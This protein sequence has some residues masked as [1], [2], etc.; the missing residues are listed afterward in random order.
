V[1]Q[2]K[3]A[4]ISTIRDEVHMGV[5][6]ISEEEITKILGVLA[7]IRKQIGIKKSDPELNKMI[8]RIDTSYPERTITEQLSRAN[9]PLV[10]KLLKDLS[11]PDNSPDKNSSYYNLL[12]LLI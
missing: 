2:N 1:S 10:E 11:H 6:L 7:E 9:K 12:I 8:Q 3:Q 4:Y 5:S